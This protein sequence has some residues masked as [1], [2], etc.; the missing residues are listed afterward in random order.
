MKHTVRLEGTYPFDVSIE[1][2][3]S[4]VLLTFQYEG[5]TSRLLLDP[6]EAL[7]IAAAMIETALEHA[8]KDSRPK[9]RKAGT[10]PR[11]STLP[12]PTFSLSL[13]S[14]YSIYTIYSI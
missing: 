3:P 12:L 13:Y 6:L 1:S 7:E 14:I 11:G 5:E 2:R 8:P 9:G 10:L 4:K